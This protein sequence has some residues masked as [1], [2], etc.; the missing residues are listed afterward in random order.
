M[1]LD[2]F[3]E[4]FRK[5]GIERERVDDLM[6]VLADFIDEKEKKFRYRYFLEQLQPDNK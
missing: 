4:I 2:L 5:S 6:L 3:Y 1:P